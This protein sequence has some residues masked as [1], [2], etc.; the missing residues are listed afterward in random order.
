MKKGNL[1]LIL[2][3]VFMISCSS[4]DDINTN[5]DD[6]NDENIG[7]LSAK[8]N[9]EE[10]IATRVRIKFVVEAG[11]VNKIGCEAEDEE[12]NLLSF[13]VAAE[14]PGTYEVNGGPF[15][16]STS[17]LDFTYEPAGESG[18]A[19]FGSQ[20]NEAIV[21]F[22]E[23][24]DFDGDDMMISGTFEF[25]VSSGNVGEFFITEGEFED[26]TWSW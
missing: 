23:I 19:G 7:S 21:T 26:V 16:Q 12:G 15:N 8:V 5:E 10:F 2:G 14:T 18:F 6:N 11:G 24:V 17:S 13:A 4:D 20:T 3:I 1:L 22:T 25:N 9:G